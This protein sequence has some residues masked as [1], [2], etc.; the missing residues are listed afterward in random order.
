MKIFKNKNKQ[1]NDKKN[2]NISTITARETYE[3]SEKWEVT[4]VILP[5]GL[6]LYIKVC[7]NNYEEDED[8]LSG[9]STFITLE[10]EKND[11]STCL[12]SINQEEF[13]GDKGLWGKQDAINEVSFTT[14]QGKTVAKDKR[15]LIV[16]SEN[17]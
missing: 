14:Q 9:A 4:K 6:N 15:N 7:N 17:K 8:F 3:Y 10:D 16:L 5:N 11:N 2:N 12:A 1:L 13:L